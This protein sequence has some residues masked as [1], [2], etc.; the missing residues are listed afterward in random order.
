MRIVAVNG[1]CY[2][3]NNN[4]DKG[5]YYKY[6]GQTFWEFISGNKDLYLK[7]IKPLG[8]TARERNAEFSKEYAQI[9]NRFTAEFS[10]NFVTDGKIDWDALVKFNSSSAKAAIR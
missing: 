2:G 3:R 6:C 7:L 1:C 9:V 5:D 8:Y 4:P 10:K